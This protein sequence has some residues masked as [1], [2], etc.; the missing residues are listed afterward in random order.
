MISPQS[1]HREAAVQLEIA[2][3]HHREA[4]LLHDV[5]AP[6]R[7]CLQADVAHLGAERALA[8][9]ARALKVTLWL[10]PNNPDTLAADANPL[11]VTLE[12]EVT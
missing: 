3:K 11:P 5:G 4:A 2:A 10:A 6:V 7:A 8:E 12:N 9:S 1:L